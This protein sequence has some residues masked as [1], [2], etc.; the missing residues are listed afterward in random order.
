MH[1]P[2]IFRF[3]RWTIVGFLMSSARRWAFRASHGNLVAQ[4]T[5][6][7]ISIATVLAAI[8]YLS[9]EAER[10]LARVR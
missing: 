5:A 8:A 4:V 6:Q 9:R 10:V 3:T 1:L 2:R 7:K